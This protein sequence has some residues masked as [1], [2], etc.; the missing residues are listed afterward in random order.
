MQKIQLHGVAFQ[1]PYI[2]FKV[3]L[4]LIIA[5][6]VMRKSV[7]LSVT[8]RILSPASPVRRKLSSSDKDLKSQN[9]SVYVSK[10]VQ[11]G[12]I[13]KTIYYQITV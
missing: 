4:T 7:A 3:I 2:Y 6:D 5:L 8:W 10:N 9:R 13:V 1:I 11:N 12:Q